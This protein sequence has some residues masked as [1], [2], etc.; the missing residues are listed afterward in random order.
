MT[1]VGPVKLIC[2]AL[3]SSYSISAYSLNKSTISSLHGIMI[4]LPA[5][6]CSAQEQ[7]NKAHAITYSCVAFEGCGH[8][9]FITYTLYYRPHTL[10]SIPGPTVKLLVCIVV[11]LLCSARELI[12][13][14]ILQQVNY[15]II[16]IIHRKSSN[17]TKLASC[18]FKYA[19]PVGVPCWYLHRNATEIWP[20]IRYL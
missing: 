9:I 1:Y 14:A 19:T 6:E 17:G 11:A 2:C 7:Q 13:G 20:G 5:R 16:I 12:G 3:V 15:S 4:Y 10:H 8:N 18:K